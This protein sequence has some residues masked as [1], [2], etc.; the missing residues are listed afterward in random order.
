VKTLYRARLLA[1]PAAAVV[2][3][4][5]LAGPGIATAAATGSPSPAAASPAAGKVVLRIGWTTEPDNLNPFIGWQ[6]QDYEIWAIN[7]DF[8]F[9]FG[10][11]SAPTLDLAAEF[12]T[13]ENGGVSADGKVWT[14]KLRPGVKWSDGQPL[15]ADDV[16]FTYDYIVKN[17]MLNMQLSTAGIVDA[18]ALDPTTVRITCSSPKA[19]MEKIFVP[20]VPRHVWQKVKPADA[21]TSFTNPVPIVGSGPFTVTKWAKGTYVQMTRNPYYWGKR[22]ALDEILFMTYTNA[23]SMTAD[24]KSGNVDAAWG[25]PVAQFAGLKQQ[26]G[27][28]ALAYPYY[29][30]EYLNFNCYEDPDSLGNPVLRDWRFRNAI[31]YAVDRETLCRIAFQGY[32]ATGTTI[33]PPKTWTDPDYHWEP[34]ATEAY[35]FDLTKAGQLLDQAGYPLKGGQRVDKEG[36]P[37]V[38][39]LSA[40]TDN[41]PSQ[42]EGKLIVGW[43][44]KLGIKVQY[45]VLDAGALLARIW[46]FKGN[47]YAPDFD[48]YVDSWLGYVDPGE[49]LMAETTAQ[50]GGTN[51][52]SWSNA[53]YDAL[54]ATQAAEL[55][56][57]KRQAIIWQMQQLMYEQTPWVVL[58]YPDYFEAYNTA[59]WTG[60]TRVNDGTGPAFYT[61]G[62]VD[63]YLN[64]E[65]VS[66]APKSGGGAGRVVLV[67]AAAVIAVAIV[68]VLVR[69]RR[70]RATEEV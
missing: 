28:E 65:P 69:R 16:A 18:K 31:D 17:N 60:W 34:S 50:I 64:L 29:N 32:A 48:L 3:Q 62:N 47:T 6:N 44:G 36:R 67:V 56:P 2:L 66:G 35:T 46:N 27:L 15:T 38:L 51:E 21:T 43:L 10:T 45:S 24:L 54:C 7:Y 37:I 41:E 33:L 39:R 5:Q 8:L 25:I 14:I 61:A 68:V 59:K 49:T 26:S 57:Q 53:R 4:A 55:D 63:S 13:R 23:D 12:P 42:A 30:W 58:A 1:V 9:G 52:P 40:T 19:D 22:P 20:I 11:S 70:P